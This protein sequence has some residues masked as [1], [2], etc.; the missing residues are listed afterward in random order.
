MKRMPLPTHLL[1][2]PFVAGTSGLPRKRLRAADLDQS[3]YGMRTQ[4]GTAPLDLLTR[5]RALAIRLRDDAAF[6]YTTAALLYGAPLPLHLERDP[7]IHLVVP[8]PES[9]PHA[10]GIRGHSSALLPGDVVARSGL[11][12]TSPARTW[13]DLAS[14][15]DIGDLVAV[16]DFLVARQLPLARIDVLRHRVSAMGSSR[17]IR[18]ARQAV[19]LVRESSESR[20]ESRLR[21]ILV[22]AG[23][24][25]PR[26]NHELVDSET[27]RHVRPDFMFVDCKVIL[28]Y[29]GDY[30]RT[31]QQWRKDMTRRSRLEAQGW[32]VM[33][34]NADD[35]A[36]PDELVV[37]VRTVIARR[38]RNI[39]EF[40]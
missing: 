38:T 16:G 24:P 33:E 21:V 30:H 2:E 3:I 22:L 28:E 27:G 18:R 7:A 4:R 29:Q 34:L 9:A 39:A 8:A 1:S 13:C 26:I 10:R 15:L 11:R 12:V 31:K 20:P 32:Y 14:I 5:C 25:E 23:L 17:G 6:S 35:L 37:R 36:N 19:E 40:A